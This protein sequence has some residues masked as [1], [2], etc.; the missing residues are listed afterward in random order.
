MIIDAFGFMRAESVDF[1][2]P[3]D[4]KLTDDFLK[5]LAQKHL[6]RFWAVSLKNHLAPS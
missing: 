4:M 3:K 1:F 6:R 5:G 2:V